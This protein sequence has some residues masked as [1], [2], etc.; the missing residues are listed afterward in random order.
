[1]DRPRTISIQIN[2]LTVVLVLL[3]IVVGT[4]VLHGYT[5][6]RD[7]ALDAASA[8][9]DEV[10]TKIFERLRGLVDPA[11]AVVGLATELNGIS[12]PPDLATHPMAPFLV[13]FLEDRPTIRSAYM[14]YSNGTFYR[15]A[16]LAG[17]NLA[18][19]R[20]RLGVP[21]ETA[22]AIFR[23]VLREDGR[24]F[25]L[26]T[27]LDKHRQ[28]VAS[29]LRR[30]PTFDARKR[31]W[32][33]QALDTSE[34]ILTGPYIFAGGKR[35][36][37]T[38]SRRFSGETLGVFG[39]DIDL[40]AI[41]E[42]LANQRFSASARLFLFNAG[43]TI[44]VHPDLV[45]TVMITDAESGAAVRTRTFEEFG[46]PVASTLFDVFQK[47]GSKGF[48]REVFHADNRSFV[49]RTMPLPESY[50][51][52]GFLAIAVPIDEFVGPVLAAGTEGII[53]AGVVLLLFLPIVI[54]VAR[55]ISRPLRR[56][57][58]EANEIRQFHLDGDLDLKTR[59]TEVA[60]LRDSMVAMKSALGSFTKYIP[61]ALVGQMIQQGLQPELGGVRREMTLMFT[62]V[63]GFTTLAEDLSPEALMR[64]TSDYFT[65]LGTVI[66]ES[67]GTIDK[68]IGDA[69]MAFWNAPQTDP[70]HA[71]AA[72]L[73]ALR[74]SRVLDSLNADWVKQGA[75]QM[76]TRFG[77]HTGE[78]VVG[79]VGSSDRMDFTAVGAAVNLASRLEGLN[80]HFGT[81]ILI[82]AD[83]L[84]DNRAHFVVRNLGKVIPKGARHPSEILELVG[85][86]PD[87][88][89]T[90]T[91][92][93][94]TEEDVDYCARWNLAFGLYLSRDW[95]AAIDAFATLSAE[96]PF[97]K[98]A[99]F[100]HERA[101]HYANQP[102]DQ[103]W[104]GT[105]AFETK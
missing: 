76:P 93:A 14:G 11:F 36:G 7:A 25:V 99:I 41:A 96:R 105:E 77:L 39:V 85:T 66:L 97:D 74:C 79:H 9:I 23:H 69:V 40:A 71:R 8:L 20:A 91:G 90:D 75:P 4:V 34:M 53:F 6:N 89:E 100:Y 80:K 13:R 44:S 63:A 55:Q 64:Q 48:R 27:F 22:F 21:D 49:A 84:R 94:A 82:S 103:D 86:R 87:A 18:D 30:D 98:A 10:G 102:P 56:L 57:A 3:V 95:Q 43:G 16:S 38:I 28:V 83:V 42:F 35:P 78:A 31:D 47:T 2:I 59:I 26:R 17:P 1:M 12:V 24:R 68:Y 104:D 62:D 73:A 92:L 46:D 51:G 81:K 72:C 33:R 52:S 58:S 67:G 37:V 29:E 19:E 101:S 88:S 65:A 45:R 61:K 32:Y 60:E 5:R 70:N 50:G 15:I 54:W